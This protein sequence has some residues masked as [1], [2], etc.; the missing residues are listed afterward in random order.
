MLVILEEIGK[1][2][3]TEITELLHLN[4]QEKTSITRNL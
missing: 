1:D 2:R 4:F 3:L